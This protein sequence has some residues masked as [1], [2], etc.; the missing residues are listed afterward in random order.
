M[1]QDTSHCMRCKTSLEGKTYIMSMMNEDII[2][3]ICKEEETRH[4]DYNKA[5]QAELEAVKKGIRNYGGL[6]KNQKYPFGRR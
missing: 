3:S 6:F 4:P 5:R 2:C 1:K